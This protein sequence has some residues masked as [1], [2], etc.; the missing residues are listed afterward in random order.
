[1]CIYLFHELPEEA[2]LAAAKEWARVLRPGGFSLF[3]GEGGAGFCFRRMGVAGRWRT[4]RVLV[5]TGRGVPMF[6]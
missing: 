4:E 6:R 1:M 5:C 2:R 3:E